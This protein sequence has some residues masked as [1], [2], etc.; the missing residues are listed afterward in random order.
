MSTALQDLR[1][2]QA[3]RKRYQADEITKD[4]AKKEA[5]PLIRSIHARAIALASK[6]GHDAKLVTFEELMA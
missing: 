6:H 2:I 1:A 5:G 4:A 3:L